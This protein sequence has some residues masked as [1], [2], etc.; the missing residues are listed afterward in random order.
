MPGCAFVDGQCV[1]P[2]TRRSIFDW[3]SCT[4]TPPHDVAHVWQGKVLPPRRPHRPLLRQHGALRLDPGK[5]RDEVRADA[6]IVRRSRAC[7]RPTWK[8]CAR[9]GCPALARAT[10]AAARTASWPS[11]SRSCGSPIPDR[12]ARGVDLYVSDM[13]RIAPASVD[14]RTKNYH[15]L[16]RGR[17]VPGLRTWRRDGGAG[18]RRRQHHRRAGLQR[19]RA[20][21]RRAAH[22]RR[23]RARRHLAPHRSSSWRAPTVWRCARRCCRWPRCGAPK[24]SSAAPAAA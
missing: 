9:A 20:G 3:A 1:A 17:A 21:R 24:R 8:C 22:A 15:W 7:A 5:T 12:Q 13:Q 14:P 4:A 19:L 16:D 23:R 2:R 11:R 6:R 18:G 10:R